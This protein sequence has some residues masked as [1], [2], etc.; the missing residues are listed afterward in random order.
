MKHVSLRSAVIGCITAVS[1]TVT[2]AFAEEIHQG[3][4]S[5]WP[6]DEIVEGVGTPDVA[7]GNDLLLSGMDASNLV[8][9]K[10][11]QAMSFDGIEEYLWIQHDGTNA[12]RSRIGP[13]SRSRSGSRET[14]P[15]SRTGASSRRAV[16][17][18]ET[19]SSTSART[20]TAMTLC[21]R[22]RSASICVMM[23]VVYR[24]T[25]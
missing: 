4:I 14:A 6:L 20:T 24:L 15:P 16:L 25:I 10:F 21:G 8:A 3:L 7:K 23:T 2:P 1:L 17:S 18:S 12:L 5:Y 19:R 13:I 11:G 22:M 9:G